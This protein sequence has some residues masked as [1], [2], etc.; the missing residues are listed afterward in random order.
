MPTDHS[1]I[2][3][4]AGP[5]S[6]TLCQRLDGATATAAAHADAISRMGVPGPVAIE[7]A[8]QMKLGVW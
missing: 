6:V 1:K 5:L 4:L 8:R 3:H 2:Q 7:I